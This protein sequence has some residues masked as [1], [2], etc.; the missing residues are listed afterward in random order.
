VPQ[1]H[2]GFQQPPNVLQRHL[3]PFDFFHAKPLNQIL[4]SD[5]ISLWKTL[6]AFSPVTLGKT[7][8]LRN[9]NENLANMASLIK[10]PIYGTDFL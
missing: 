3:F 4:G 10:R 2:A 7:K 9:D 8:A 6:Y 1:Q 5:R